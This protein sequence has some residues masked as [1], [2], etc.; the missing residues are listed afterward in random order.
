[1]SARGQ[2]S[3]RVR[4]DDVAAAVDEGDAYRG[5]AH[6]HARFERVGWIAEQPRGGERKKP[7]ARPCRDPHRLPVRRDDDAHGLAAGI[8]SRHHGVG[9]IL[10]DGIN[11]MLGRDPDLHHPPRLSWHKLISALSDA[12]IRI[13]EQDLTAVPLAVELSPEAKAE[14]DRS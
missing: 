13:T 5:L 4:D 8:D 12:G 6:R 9:W 7:V 11:Q 2:E 10:Q 3:V 1:M 14:L